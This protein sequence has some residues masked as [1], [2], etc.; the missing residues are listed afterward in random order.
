M[1]ASLFCSVPMCAQ[2]NLIMRLL[3]TGAVRGDGD[4]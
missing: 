3:R 2:V 4:R 1:A